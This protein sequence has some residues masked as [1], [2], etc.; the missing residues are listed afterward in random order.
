MKPTL[1]VEARKAVA[2]LKVGKVLD[3]SNISVELL[4]GKCKAMICMLN[5]VLN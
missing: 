2:K 1:S 5:V 3:I 4:K